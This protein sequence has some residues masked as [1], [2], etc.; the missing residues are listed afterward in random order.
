MKHTYNENWYKNYNVLYL[1]EFSSKDLEDFLP[2]YLYKFMS[3][4]LLFKEF[5]TSLPKP[6]L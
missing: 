3:I 1:T 2:L 6:K 4:F 5:T